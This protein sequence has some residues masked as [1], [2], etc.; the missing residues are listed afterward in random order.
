MRFSAFKPVWIFFVVPSVLVSAVALWNKTD[1]KDPRTC[2]YNEALA[3]L[4][5]RSDLYQ[6]M[7]AAESRARGLGFIVARPDD[8]RSREDFFVVSMQQRQGFVVVNMAVGEA[9]D[10]YP[11]LVQCTDFDIAGDP[12]VIQEILDLL[13][14][15]GQ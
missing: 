4:Q 8:A 15:S 9:M 11:H 5:S 7:P 13:S 3:V 1:R 14:K 10:E 12:D 6:I 2:T